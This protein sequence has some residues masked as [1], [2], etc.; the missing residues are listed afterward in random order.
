MTSA[1]ATGF[2]YC[3]SR[4]FVGLLL[5]VAGLAAASVLI[6]ALP[7]A[8]KLLLIALVALATLHAGLAFFACPIVAV[9]W[10]GGSGWSVRM[11]EG[12]DAA[13]SLTSFRVAGRFVLLRLRTP[14]HGVHAVLLTPDN[15]DADT[16]RRLRMRLA[17]MQVEAQSAR[18]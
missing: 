3:P 9:G 18:F 11:A 4:R 10:N 13:A 2:E 17:V 5:G 16:R 7:L 8:L 6:A 14:H 15:S 1:P 12:Q